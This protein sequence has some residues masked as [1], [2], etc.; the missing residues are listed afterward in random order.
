MFGNRSLIVDV[1]ERENGKMDTEY[2]TEEKS[3]SRDRTKLDNA[4]RHHTTCRRRTEAS[5]LI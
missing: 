2:L 5:D 3:S 4:M 1:F